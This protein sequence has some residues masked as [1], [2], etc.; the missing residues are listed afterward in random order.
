MKTETYKG[1]KITFKKYQNG[2]VLGETRGFIVGV[3]KTKE[4]TF[5]CLK[6]K[7]N[8][9][10]SQWDKRTTKGKYYTLEEA[11]QMLGV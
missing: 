9:A 3:Y 6:D 10:E 8:K 2:F 11:K 5:E 7:I 4:E 1:Y